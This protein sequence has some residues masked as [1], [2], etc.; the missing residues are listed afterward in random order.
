M[1]VSILKEQIFCSVNKIV[2]VENENASDELR[3]IP[4]YVQ[5]WDIYDDIVESMR[6][7]PISVIMQIILLTNYN[8]ICLER[9]I[10]SLGIVYMCLNKNIFNLK[11]KNLSELWEDIYKE[12]MPKNQ[13]IKAIERKK[14]IVVIPYTRKLHLPT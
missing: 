6:L 10:K 12:K 2:E 11:N 9:N 4:L 13:N 5:R 14:R 3:R 7:K 1:G 8:E